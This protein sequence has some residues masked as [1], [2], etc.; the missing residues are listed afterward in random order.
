M[1]SGEPFEEKA[2]RLLEAILKRLEEIERELASLKSPPDY[3]DP[4]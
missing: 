3:G 1:A 4:I 2:I